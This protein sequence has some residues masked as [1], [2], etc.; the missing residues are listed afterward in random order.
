M[1]F[2]YPL[3][4]P[5]ATWKKVVLGLSAITLILPIIL[6]FRLIGALADTAEYKQYWEGRLNQHASENAIRLVVL[7]DSA[8]QGVGAKSPEEGLAGLIERYIGEK[9]GRPVYVANISVTGAKV[10]DVLEKQLPKLSGLRADIV[11]VSVSGNDANKRVPLDR[12]TAD[13]TKLYAALPSDRTV[14]SDV[15]GVDNREW[16][17]PVLLEAANKTG[18][19]VAPV[20]EN[21]HPHSD[22]FSAYAGDFFHP[23]SRGYT[24]WFNA[25][26]PHIDDILATLEKTG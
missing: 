18:I 2:R 19:Y 16:Y 14:V 11:I 9:T 22:E 3:I 6:I 8:A 24:F 21:F 15:P 12:F 20:Y 23:S 25:Y 4:Y 5:V 26:R 13:I 1:R 7:G 17:Q 10:S